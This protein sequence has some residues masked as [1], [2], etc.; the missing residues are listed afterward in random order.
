[1][2][3][4]YFD[5]TDKVIIVTGATGV[6]GEAFVK[7]LHAYGATIVLIGRNESIGHSR[8][9]ALNIKGEKAPIC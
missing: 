8:M 9:E 5:L 1:M 2:A 6:L 7:G 3:G 4:T